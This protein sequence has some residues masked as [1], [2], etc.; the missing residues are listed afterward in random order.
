MLDVIQIDIV[1]KNSKCSPSSPWMYALLHLQPV[2]S[3]DI[4]ATVSYAI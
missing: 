2:L 1:F 3:F 4:P